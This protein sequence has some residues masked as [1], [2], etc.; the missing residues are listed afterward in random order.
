MVYFPPAHSV[1]LWSISHQLPR[2]AYG[3]FPLISLGTPMG[4]F[5]FIK[6]KSIFDITKNPQKCNNLY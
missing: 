6:Y 2:Y 4:Y 1:R 3:L 5:P